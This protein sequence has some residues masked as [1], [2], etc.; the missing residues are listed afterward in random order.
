M[1]RLALIACLLAAPAL[2]QDADPAAV[3]AMVTAI[4]GAGCSVT[5]ENGDAVLAASGL[6]EEQTMAVIAQLYAE[7]RV[8]LAAD[9]SMTMSGPGCE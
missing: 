6:T 5:T 2:A 1:K 3:D 9:G 4:V 8:A 7:G